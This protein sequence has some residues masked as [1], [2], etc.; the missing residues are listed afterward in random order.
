ML[1]CGCA[2]KYSAIICAL[3]Q[4]RSILIARVFKPL[5]I[6]QASCGLIVAPMS[7][8]TVIFISVICSI[9]PHTMPATTSPWPFKYLVALCT[10]IPIPYCL[11]DWS[12][13]VKKVLSTTLIKLCCLATAPINAKSITAIVGLIGVSTNIIFEL[14]LIAARSSSSLVISTKVTSIPQRGNMCEKNAKVHPYKALD[15][16]K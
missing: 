6:S 5:L 4:W 13:G 8:S 14:G 16:I 9:D 15:A 7:L 1:T 11:G 10:I 2:S 12:N 3:T